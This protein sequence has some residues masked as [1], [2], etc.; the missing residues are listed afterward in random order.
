MRTDGHG[1]RLTDEQTD[2]HAERQTDMTK[3]IVACEILRKHL[4]TAQHK[5]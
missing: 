3:V 2:R 1:D 4:K 5:K